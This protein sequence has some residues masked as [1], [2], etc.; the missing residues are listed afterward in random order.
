[1][2]KAALKVFKQQ[3]N[4]FH[5][6]LCDMEEES[7]EGDSYFRYLMRWFEVAE[8]LMKND[9]DPFKVPEPLEERIN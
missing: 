8:L 1:M 7:Y 5:L 4:S 3:Y 2:T 9:V 6:H